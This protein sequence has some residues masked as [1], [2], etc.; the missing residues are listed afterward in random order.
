MPRSGKT[1]QQALACLV[2]C[3]PWPHSLEEEYSIF[4]VQRE[5]SAN[6]PAQLPKS[7]IVASLLIALLSLASRRG[8][9]HIICLSRAEWRS[10][11]IAL[12]ISACSRSS[13][14]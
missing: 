11:S 2:C 7:I 6:S 12:S 3:G 1:V 13:R 9:G 14:R 5:H 8:Q 4:H 10:A